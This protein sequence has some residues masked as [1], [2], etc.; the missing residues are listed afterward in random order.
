VLALL[1]E[2][3]VFAGIAIS[4]CMLSRYSLVGWVPAFLLFLVLRGKIKKAFVFS[5]TG[6]ACL[7]ILFILPFGWELIHELAQ[8]PGKYIPFA[9]RV[10][11]DSPDVF[12]GGAGMARF[13]GPSH[14]ALQHTL[15][16]SLSFAVPAG[17]MIVCHY[18]GKKIPLANIPLAAL[19]ICVVVFYNLIDVPYLYLFY[20]SSFIS[21]V[22]V[23]FFLKHN[24]DG[25]A[26]A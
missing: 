16:I 23:A 21:L 11:A 9:A 24:D 1:S 2:H 13:F 20:T 8:L 14:I 4:L 17:F 7:V 22:V 6:L 19:K 5:A 10:W 3:I 15:L 12:S 25:L 18:V 26:T